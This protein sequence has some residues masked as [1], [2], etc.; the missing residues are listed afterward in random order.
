MCVAG[1]M[2]LKSFVEMKIT[3]NSFRFL[4]TP[5]LS[6]QGDIWEEFSL[7]LMEWH[8]LQPF[9][10]IA[11]NGNAL[12]FPAKISTQFIIV[13]QMYNLLRHRRELG[14]GPLEHRLGS[15]ALQQGPLNFEERN[16]F[17]PSNWSFRPFWLSLPTC[18]YQLIR[19][20]KNVSHLDQSRA[21]SL[22]GCL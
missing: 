7:E 15:R 14:T 10:L 22:R 21:V 3:L 5:I 16:S 13:R 2:S 19:A 11:C 8:I 17:L 12:Y 20:R 9:C 18:N 6:F 4:I 1:V